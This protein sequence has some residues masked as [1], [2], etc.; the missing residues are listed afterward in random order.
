MSAPVAPLPSPASLEAAPEAA[1]TRR[2][3]PPPDWPSDRLEGPEAK[4]L[5]L[6]ALAGLVERLERHDG[7]SAVIRRQERVGGRLL[8]E[9][10][11]RMKVRHRP[12]S[13]Y[14]RNI[15]VQDGFEVIFVE[16]LRDGKL[17]HHSGGLAGRLLPVLELSPRSPLAMSQS[18]FPITEAGLLSAARML[19][20]DCRRDLG[21]PG[22]SIVLDRLVDPEGHTRYRSRLRYDAPAPGRPFSRVEVLYDPG[23]FLLREMTFS[24]WPEAPGP[25]EPLLGGRFV[26]VEFDPSAVPSDRDFD[27]TNPAY[28]FR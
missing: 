1:A 7:Y 27:A 17:I 13:I 5:L 11:L 25:G 9:Q 26:V 18:R 16:G 15:G 23:T 3:A 2:T 8:A 12:A 14:V 6:D 22:A 10:T 20:D 24:D 19:R 21:E 4:R 28:D